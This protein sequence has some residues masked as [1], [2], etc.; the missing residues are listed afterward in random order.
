VLHA[1][2]LKAKQHIGT[3]LADERMAEL[4]TEP[5]PAEFGIVEALDRTQE[6]SAVPHPLHHIVAE[7]E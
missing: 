2:V 1:E 7:V 3:A 5:E 4:P 6:E